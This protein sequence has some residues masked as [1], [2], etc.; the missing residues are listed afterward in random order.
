LSELHSEEKFDASQICKTSFSRSNNGSGHAIASSRETRS[1]CETRVKLFTETRSVMRR[2]RKRKRKFSCGL[3]NKRFISRYDLESYQGFQWRTIFL[4]AK[5]V[6][7]RS[8][9]AQT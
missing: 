8:L 3:C 2:F 1:R 5:C 9:S 7:K 4:R 6:I